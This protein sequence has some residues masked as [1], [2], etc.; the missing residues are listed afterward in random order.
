MYDFPL[1]LRKN[2]IFITILGQ[3]DDMKEPNRVYIKNDPYIDK[4]GNIILYKK[5]RMIDLQL[6]LLV[7]DII[8]IPGSFM[9]NTAGEAIITLFD[10]PLNVKHFDIYTSEN[11]ENIS[12]MNIN[13]DISSIKDNFL[14][15]QPADIERFMIK[16]EDDAFCKII[17]STIIRKNISISLLKNREKYAYHISNLQFSLIHDTIMTTK[18]FNRWCKLLGC[19]YIVVFTNDVNSVVYDSRKPYTTKIG[20]MEYNHSNSAYVQTDFFRFL[21]ENVLNLSTIGTFKTSNNQLYKKMITIINQT[22]PISLRY[23]LLICDFVEYHFDVKLYD[24][25]TSSHI[26]T[27]TSVDNTI[28]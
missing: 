28:Y 17:K 14:Q 6:S 7:N 22:I 15:S 4:D 24:I 12:L 9:F 20:D 25:N 13:N 5:Y 1:I 23:M 18:T 2:G 27:Y 3:V 10:N 8:Y 21:I 26:L 16:P 11:I 19:Y